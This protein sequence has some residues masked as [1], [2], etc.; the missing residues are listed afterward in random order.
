MPGTDGKPRRPPARSPGL[1]A[2]DA[3]LWAHVTKDVKPLRKPPAAKAPAADT[4]AAPPPKPRQAALRRP[5]PLPPADLPPP[6]YKGPAA[7]ELSHGK[8]PGLD[9]RTSARLKRGQMEIDGRLDL[10]G[11]TQAEA[12]RALTGYLIGAHGQGRR[13][14]LVITGKGLKETGEIGVLRRAV[15]GWLNAPPLRALVHAFT[16]AAPKDGGEGALYVLLKK[17][18]EA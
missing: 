11:M 14:I 3:A 1:A 2:E 12:Y 16:Y 6:V 9:R 18:K 4:P 17:R 5:H 10:H 8:A 13:C 7:P 15:P